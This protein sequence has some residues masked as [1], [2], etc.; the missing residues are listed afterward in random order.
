[1]KPNKWI[2]HFEDPLKF[3]AQF[4]KILSSE[5]VDN[6][7]KEGTISLWGQVHCEANRHSF[8]VNRTN[9]FFCAGINDVAV[10]GNTTDQEGYSFYATIPLFLIFN[11]NMDIQ[12]SF[13]T[14]QLDKP[15]G[16]PNFRVRIR[17]DCKAKFSNQWESEHRNP[18]NGKLF[19]HHPVEISQEQVSIFQAKTYAQLQEKVLQKIQESFITPKTRS[20]LINQF[21]YMTDLNEDFQAW[22]ATRYH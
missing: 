18:T 10:L 15:G 1:M 5:G 16:T 11:G 20:N 12:G 19:D 14:Y 22:L 9:N 6:T 8:A 17:V 3:T 13:L 4:A 7:R 2:E 21:K